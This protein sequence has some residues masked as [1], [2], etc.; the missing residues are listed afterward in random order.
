MLASGVMAAYNHNDQTAATREDLRDLRDTL[1]DAMRDGF[2]GVHDRQDKT[3]GR[4]LKTEHDVIRMD[5]TLQAALERIKTIFKMLDRR[6]RREGDPQDE[7]GEYIDAPRRKQYSTKVLVGSVVGATLAISE[8]LQ[9]II[10]A[11]LEALK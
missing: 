6:L 4:V 1:A 2:K 7:E 3:N 8:A 9:R 11:V 10:P 5:V